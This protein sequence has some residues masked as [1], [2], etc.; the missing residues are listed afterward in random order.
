MLV[1]GV[2]GSPYAVG[3]FGYAY[4]KENKGKLQALSVKRRKATRSNG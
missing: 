1:Q 3:Y 4:Y 2:E